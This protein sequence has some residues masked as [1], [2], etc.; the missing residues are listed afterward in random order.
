MKY[1]V[2]EQVLIAFKND[3][4][5][6]KLNVYNNTEYNFFV[7]DTLDGLQ[8]LS[9]WEFAE[10]AL[11]DLNDQRELYDFNC[12]NEELKVYTR[13]YLKSLIG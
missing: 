1:K 6:L 4:C 5:V 3:L 9:G 12:R 13:T 8:I 10:D 2:E 11:D 7:C